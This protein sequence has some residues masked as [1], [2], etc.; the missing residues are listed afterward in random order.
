MGPAPIW[1][2]GPKRELKKPRLEGFVSNRAAIRRPVRQGQTRTRSRDKN[3][4]YFF[5]TTTTTISQQPRHRAARKVTR[6]T[7]GPSSVGKSRSS[8]QKK[9]RP[10]ALHYDL[11]SSVYYSGYQVPGNRPTGDSV[12]AA[13]PNGPDLSV[14]LW[15][16]AASLSLHYS[17][18]DHPG[19]NRRVLPALFIPFVSSNQFRTTLPKVSSTFY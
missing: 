2:L 5:F 4:Y 15:L 12:D 13:H 9:Q 17:C 3:R 6:R 1:W 7:P 18:F 19:L 10:L 8:N 16:H 11:P 14:S